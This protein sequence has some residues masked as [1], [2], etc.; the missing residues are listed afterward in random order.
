MIIYCTKCWKDN[1]AYSNECLHCG[2]QLERG[3]SIDFVTKL[4]HAL[5]HP[6]PMTVERAAWILGELK[7]HEARDALIELLQTSQ[8]M[9]ALEKAVEALGKIGDDRAIDVLSHMLTRSY[10]PVRVKVV[11]ALKRIG[12]APA[13]SVLRKAL[14]DPAS[15]VSKNAKEAIEILKSG[16]K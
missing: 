10:L 5:Q 6:E 3:N 12:S 11:E 7:A 13:I 4:I 9:G 8:D 15:T 1:P 16:G 2:A 14:N